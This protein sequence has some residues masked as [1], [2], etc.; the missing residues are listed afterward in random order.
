MGGLSLGALAAWACCHRV[1]A[2]IR[3]RLFIAH[4]TCQSPRP[5]PHPAG[6]LS[7]QARS[8]PLLP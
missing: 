2:E 3:P 8:R 5:H 7:P 1:L 6:T 4:H